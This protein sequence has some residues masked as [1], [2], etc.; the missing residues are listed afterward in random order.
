YCGVATHH[1]GER[2]LGTRCEHSG[3]GRVGLQRLKLAGAKPTAAPEELRGLVTAVDH[4]LGFDPGGQIG[5]ALLTAENCQRRC[6]T[7]SAISVDDAL[8]WAIKKLDN[9]TP[10]AAGLDTFLYWETGNSGRKF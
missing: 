3:T 2:R 9:Q 8:N 1:L 10:D 6:V 4:Y 7:Y 5:V